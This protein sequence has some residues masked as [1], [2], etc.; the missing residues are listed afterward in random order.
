MGFDVDDVNKLAATGKQIPSVGDGHAFPTGPGRRSQAG[1]QTLEDTAP[2]VTWAVR[3]SR[4]GGDRRPTRRLPVSRTVLNVSGLSDVEQRIP[5][6]IRLAVQR[7]RHLYRV[8]QGFD[9]S[10]VALS[11]GIQKMVRSDI[12]ASGVY[13]RWSPPSGF[14][15]AVFVTAS[16]GLGEM[17]VQVPSTPMSSMCTNRPLR[18]GEWRS[19]S[20]MSAARRSR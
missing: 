16:Y 13:S 5:R 3:S 12:G 15:D 9:H 2:G 14:R 17:V 1:H 18:P 4:D 20:A 7:S 11:A 19:C 10:L 8:H 6:G